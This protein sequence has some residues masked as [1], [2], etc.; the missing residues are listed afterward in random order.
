[1]SSSL[2]LFVNGQVVPQGSKIAF[3]YVPKGET[4]GRL[5][6]R[7][8]AGDALTRWRHTIVDRAVEALGQHPGWTSERVMG[9]AYSV[10]LDFFIMRPKSHYLPANTKRPVPLLRE[11]ALAYPIGMP[12]VDKL[13]RAVL[14]GLTT[15]GI[16]FDD[17]QV[18]EVQATKHF[19]DGLLGELSQPGCLITVTKMLDL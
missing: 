17:S 18:I 10:R 16:W 12:D 3:R 4:K 2:T 6:V 1:M 8:V 11:D 7:E 5:G 9:E 13:T 15:A 19:S 14:D